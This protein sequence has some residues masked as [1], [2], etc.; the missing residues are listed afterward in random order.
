MLHVQ[1]AGQFPHIAYSELLSR[2]SKR[3]NAAIIAAPY[4][5]NL[6]HFELSKKSGE[7]LR[8]AVVQCEENG[9]YSTT[10]PKF[11]LGHS[12][13][14]K[15]LSI[16][17][18]AS[19]VRDTEGIGFM[20]YNNFGFKDTISMV[21]DFADDLDSGDDADGN[22][23]GSNFNV[24]GPMLDQILNFAEEAVGMMGFEF[25]PDPATMDRIV[26]MKYDDALQKKTR[27]FVY[28][29]DDLDSSKGFIDACSGTGAGPS[30][31]RLKGK[32]LSPVYVKLGIDDLEIADE[33]KPFVNEASG[34][35]QSA[36]FGDEEA[37]NGTVDE[38]C[39]WIMGKEPNERSLLTGAVT[40]RNG[41]E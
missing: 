19:G 26:E 18:S 4:P 14:S 1:C 37:M 39:D 5:L 12:L 25:T 41:E 40:E 29:N 20:S 11:Y 24:Q 22:G 36:S 10:L 6:D 31:S 28:D 2:V 13:G 33:V 21:K 23:K 7:A 3:L 17:L 34:G 9:N 35:F 30:I 38:I 8:R 15:L 27:L 16:A 32:H